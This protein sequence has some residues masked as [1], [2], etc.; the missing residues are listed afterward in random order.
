MLVLCL[1]FENDTQVG[2]GDFVESIFQS[3]GEVGTWEELGN[4]G[5]AEE[6]VRRALPHL[7]FTISSLHP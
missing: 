7:L 6:P 4:G 2:D 5:G 1:V 3:V